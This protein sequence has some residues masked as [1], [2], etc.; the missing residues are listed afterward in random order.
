MFY[1]ANGRYVE[2]ESTGEVFNMIA[3]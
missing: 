3:A 2:V 1:Y